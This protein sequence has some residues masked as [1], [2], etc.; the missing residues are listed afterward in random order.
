MILALHSCPPTGTA[1]TTA[2]LGVLAVLASQPLPTRPYQRA[3]LQD[4]H[5]VRKHCTHCPLLLPDIQNEDGHADAMAEIK[6][7]GTYMFTTGSGKQQFVGLLF[8]ATAR[9]IIELR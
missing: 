3:V 9:R 5:H 6:N 1:L 8:E 2:M 4:C 7:C